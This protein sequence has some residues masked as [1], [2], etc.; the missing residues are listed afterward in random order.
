MAR[1]R[2]KDIRF[3]TELII[4]TILSLVAASLWI[5][6]IKTLISTH[7]KNQPLVL[8]GVALTITLLAIF[9]LQYAFTNPPDDESSKK[10]IPP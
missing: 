8:A 3:Y 10:N 1:T 5:E 7:F 9:G 4:T 6:F 2:A